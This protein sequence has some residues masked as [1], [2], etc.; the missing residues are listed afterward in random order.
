M[1]NWPTGRAYFVLKRARSGE[2]W[3]T[4]PMLGANFRHT[5]LSTY[6]G[7]IGNHTDFGSL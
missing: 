4:V 1:T 2:S 5:S 3:Q 6:C 7:I